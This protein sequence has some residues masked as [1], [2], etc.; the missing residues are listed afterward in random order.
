METR[1]SI[2]PQCRPCIRGRGQREIG[3]EGTYSLYHD[4]FVGTGSNGDVVRA[5]WSFDG[6]NLRF[7]DVEPQGPYSVVWGSEPWT[8]RSP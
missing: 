4:R 7:A 1:C 3:I 5:R 6:T 8:R 2:R